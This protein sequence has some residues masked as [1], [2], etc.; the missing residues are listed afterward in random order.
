MTRRLLSLL[1]G[2]ALAAC[3][4]CVQ[5][6]LL[7][8]VGMD[9]PKSP[10]GPVDSFILRTDGKLVSEPSAATLPP[11][12]SS[13]LEAA[14]SHFRKEEYYKAEA[15]FGRV[16]DRDKGPPLAIQEAMYY[17]AECLRLSGHLP[18]ACDTYAALLNKFP[19]S[20]YREQCCQRMYDI[21]NYWLDDTWDE[22]KRTKDGKEWLP[23]FNWFHFGNTK[24]FFD[25]EGRAIEAMEKVRLYDLSGPLAD[26]ALYRCGVVKMYR[27]DWREAD[28]YFSQVALRHPESELAPRALQFAVFSKQMATGG[29][30]YDGRK[31]AEARKLIQTALASYPQIAN[32]PKKR[33][34][35]ERQRQS[36]DEQ[37][38]DK[39]LKMAEFYRR[40]GHPASAYYYYELVR[41][42]YPNTEAARK[43]AERWNGL[44][45]ELEAKGQGVSA[46]PQPPQ[47]Q[48]PAAPAAP[49]SGGWEQPGT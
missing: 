22:M 31:T 7:P 11:E 4:G 24:P 18:K 28:H 8:Y 40:T 23:S 12:I 20:S 49:V 30:D 39:E 32:D 44:R 1:A 36:I 3:V 46:Q 26:Q 48:A 38:A 42:R 47:P 15:L 45:A 14:R 27:E 19:T 35:L 17:R 41:R 16:A 10:D 5:P 29:S 43:A 2:P 6:S 21:A 25:S 33:E 37:Q 34:Y 13:T 9:T